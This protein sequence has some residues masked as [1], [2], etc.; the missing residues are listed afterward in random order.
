MTWMISCIECQTRDEVVVVPPA[1]DS[2]ERMV[3][4]VRYQRIQVFD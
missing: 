4:V 1:E 3:A 2:G